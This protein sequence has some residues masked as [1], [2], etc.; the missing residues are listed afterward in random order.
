MLIMSS[1]LWLAFP[2]GEG[3]MPTEAVQQLLLG[4]WTSS[5]TAPYI[6]NLCSAEIFDRN[7]NL[8]RVL[9]LSKSRF[10]TAKYSSPVCFLGFFLS[11]WMFS[12]FALLCKSYTAERVFHPQLWVCWALFSAH[13]LYLEYMDTNS[14][15]P[16]LWIAWNQWISPL[17]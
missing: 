2:A 10:Q 3:W 13:L 17:I 12:G 15:G 11:T 6:L 8:E 5:V 16:Q 4:V 1:N 14:R 7:T 9:C